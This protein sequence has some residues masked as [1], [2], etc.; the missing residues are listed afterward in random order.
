MHYEGRLDSRD[1]NS[2][3]QP[4]LCMFGVHFR[5]LSSF[6]RTR[7]L[8][9]HDTVVPV[10][11]C[12]IATSGLICSRPSSKTPFGFEIPALLLTFGELE[13]EMAETII[14]LIIERAPSSRR[15]RPSS[16]S[17]KVKVNRSLA[18]SARPSAF[19][20]RVRPPAAFFLVNRRIS[21]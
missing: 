5:T 1:K 18:L 16:N 6:P 12:S 17:G 8:N 20:V 14:A 19:A 2:S 9:S 13:N 7:M 3:T 11:A 4:K 15:R 10:V 21:R